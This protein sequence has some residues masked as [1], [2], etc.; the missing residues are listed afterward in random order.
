MD[1][2]ALLQ[3]IGDEQPSG[4]NLEYEYSFSA[5]E[6]ASAYGEERQVG[7][8]VIEGEE[9]NWGE[10][11]E[12]A[13]EVL[14]ESHDIRAAVFLTEA[15]LRRE[16]LS[17]FT[18][19]VTLVHGY[20][21][22]FWDSCHPQPDEDDGDVTMRIN[23]VQGLADRDRM[24]PGLRRVGL[25]QS[26]SFGAISLRDVELADGKIDPGP[27]E[28]VPKLSTISA[29]FRD[30]SSEWLSEQSDAVRDARSQV[31]A[32]DAIFAD[33][34]PG[35][36]PQLDRLIKTLDAMAEVFSRFVLGEAPDGDAGDAD[37][38]A[39]DGAA[40]ASAGE[41]PAAGG[42]GGGGGAITS[43]DDV[44][45]ALD[46]II[47]YYN[48]AEPSSPVPV[49]LGRARRLV[50]ADFLTIVRD[51]AAEGMDEVRKVGGLKDDEYE[52]DDD[53]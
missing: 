51:M 42:G 37:A 14:K 52:D 18:E 24:L 11:A 45:R 16:G 43:P 33:K 40:S 19:G 38:G 29:A 50:G 3:P 39:G 31:A 27:D 22:R 36:G 26:R 46:R 35:E 49:I 8:S 32:I 21:D 41:A 17:G 44:R 15:Q 2:D 13:T 23:A 4:E 48:R 25:T 7:D 10:L 47:T 30:T 20:L 5:M 12:H 53:D 34:T 1:V 6:L 9:P 28:D